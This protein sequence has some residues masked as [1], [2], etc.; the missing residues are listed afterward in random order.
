V[1]VVLRLAADQKGSASNRRR[2]EELDVLEG[3]RNAKLG[4][5]D[6]TRT[7]SQVGD[8]RR[9]SGPLDAGKAGPIR[10]KIV[11]LA[12][13]VRAPMIVKRLLRVRFTS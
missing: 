4:R 11:R 3:T 13:A 12:R 9:R 6:A 7:P 10:L 5:R 2:L 1:R 8:R